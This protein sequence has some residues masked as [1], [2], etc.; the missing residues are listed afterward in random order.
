LRGLKALSLIDAVSVYRDSLLRW[1]VALPILIALVGRFFLPIIIERLEE[2]LHITVGQFYPV[3]M[4]YALLTTAPAMCGMVVGFLLLDERDDRT[5]LAL[6]VTPLS[7][8]NYLI[9]RLSMPMLTSIVITLVVFPL[10]G[11]ENPGLIRLSISALA[12]SPLAPLMALA[13][14]T[15]AENKV[16]GFALVKA[17]GLFLVAPLVANFVHSSWQIA[18]GIIPVYWS[19]RLLWAFQ[20]GEPSPWIYLAVGLAYQLLLLGILIRRFNTKIVL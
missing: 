1:I 14:A 8:I 20:Q 2:T 12:A 10:A 6:R 5:L 15:V 17:S 7:T 11:M 3:V 18:F 16:Q 9:W 13:L 4:S 19:A